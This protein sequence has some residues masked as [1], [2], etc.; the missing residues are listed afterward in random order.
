M[1]E[2]LEL[3]RGALGRDALGLG[4]GLAHP[5]ESPEWRAM[6]L[7]QK[8]EFFAPIWRVMR[9]NNMSVEQVCVAVC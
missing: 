8:L 9:D 6:D 7:A 2:R 1:R 4:A 5:R 3:G